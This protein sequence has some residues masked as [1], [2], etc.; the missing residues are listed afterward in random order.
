MW[1]MCGR[2]GS[3]GPGADIRPLSLAHRLAEPA[4]PVRSVAAL[5][6]A[7]AQPYERLLAAVDELP[8][9]AVFV[10]ATARSDA[11]GGWGELITTACLARGAAGALTDGLVRD[12]TR[13]LDSGF[14]VFSRGAIPYD[15]KGRIDVAGHG[16]P[17][18]VD[19]VRI[20]ADDVIVADADGV[21]VVPQA[22]APRVLELAADKQAGEGDFRAAVRAG[23]PVTD[24]FR[25]YGVL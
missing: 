14:P 3:G 13:V 24:A 17:V 2:G 1:S 10:F 12:V 18:A 22:L 19:G 5:E 16:A 15:S 21:C 8:P 7:P 4:F 6:I 25:A 20:A 9:A 11:A 23:T